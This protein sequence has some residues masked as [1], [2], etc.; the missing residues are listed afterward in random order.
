M[1]LCLKLATH[2]TAFVRS[3]LAKRPCA[4]ELAAAI[5]FGNL[6]RRS[7]LLPEI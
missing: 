1:P 5:S 3:W 7:G 4:N 6:E 2:K